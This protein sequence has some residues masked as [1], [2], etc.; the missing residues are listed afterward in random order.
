M[1]FEALRQG[2]THRKRR[3]NRRSKVGRQ[4]KWAF[5][6]RSNLVELL[7]TRC[8]LT[9]VVGPFPPNDPSFPDQWNLVNTGQVGSTP[10]QDINV[11]PA[12]QQGLT[13][14]G[15]TV[16]VVD[17]G[18]DPNHP[19]LAANYSSS[20]S[21][22]YLEGLQNPTPPLPLAAGAD[23]GT[24]MAGIIAAVANNG[25]GVSGVAPN[26]QFAALRAVGSAGGQLAPGT[27]QQISNAESAHQQQI[28]IYNNSWTDQYLPNGTN[29]PP[30]PSPTTQKTAY[31]M[32]LAAIQKG[33]IGLPKAN[34]PVPAGRA[35][36]GNIYVFAAGDGAAYND[37]VNYSAVANSP[38]VIAVGGVNQ[39]GMPTV[40]SDP[41]A[42]LLVSAPT[43]NDVLGAADE[44]GLPT[45]DIIDGP[46]VNG[47][48]TITDTYVGNDQ[49]GATGTGAA[50]AEVS[51][52]IALMLQ[53]NPKLSYRDV[54]MILAETAS[55]NDPTDPGWMTNTMSV[56]SDGAV[57]PTADVGSTPLPT[58]V[59]VSP[60]HFDNAFGF[61]VV[62]AAAAVALAKTWT[63]LQPLSTLSS[64]L[65]AVN[66]AI[67]DGV[68]TGV[69]SSVTFTQGLHVEHAQVTFQ[70]DILSAG[71]LQIT[72][73]S[74]NG[75]R[76]VL[77]AERTNDTTTGVAGGGNLN[78]Y[79][80]GWT[81]TTDEDWGENSAGTWTLQVADRNQ[82]GITGTFQNWTLNL[83]GTQDYAPI[84][85]NFSLSTQ[86][87]Q[88]ASFNVL[89][90]TYDTDGTYTIAPGS[91]SIL[92][93]PA[94]GTLSVNAQTGQI[95][96]TPNFGFSGADSFTYTV[97]DTNGV[98]SRTATV[99]LDVGKLNQTPVANN[100]STSTLAHT[101]VSIDIL[102]N[103]TDASGSLLPSTVKIVQQPNFGTVSV[104]PVTGIATYTP[105]PNFTV[106][107]S[108]QYTV[109]DS[110]GL[111]S[112]VATVTIN[113]T[114]STPVASSF[115]E[116]AADQNVVQ[117]INVLNFVTGPADPGHVTIITPPQNGTATVDPTTGI[118]RYTPLPNFFG[119]DSLN[120]AVANS[121]GALSNAATVSLTVLP[122]GLPVALNHEFVLVP[123]QSVIEG[124]RALDNP[125]NSGALVALLNTQP[126]FGTVTMN[127]DGSFT[128]AQGPSFPGID[129]FTYVVNNGQG[130][131]APATIRLVSPTVNYVEQLYRVVLNRSASDGELLYFAGQLNAGVSRAQVAAEFLGSSEYLGG[132]VNSAYEQVLS[133]PADAGGQIYWV[134]QMHAGLT[135][136]ALL[137][138]LAGS[139]EYIARH[140]GSNQAVVAGFY[141]TFL[142]R[143]A[144]FPD[145]VYWA[146]QISAGEPASL[147]AL[148]FV[149]SAEYRS[150]FAQSLFQ[151]DLHTPISAAAA[152]GFQSSLGVAASRLQIQI[153]ILSS[154]TFYTN[155]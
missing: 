17:T 39:Q 139:P 144:S 106:S 65:I 64:G 135:Q 19:D 114:Q 89:S 103:D 1:V 126:Q 3:Q 13:G 80:A 142:N 38:Y 116:P 69:S 58:G 5:L 51:G 125:T 68:A 14:Q 74:P 42:A 77:A 49:N 133:R 81:F 45:T 12:W 40:T 131:S 10:L 115:S 91:L 59:T 141:Q 105:G 41:G 97:H 29:N 66:Q 129:S 136:E 134:A 151:N 98:A 31:P 15:V 127:P 43:G 57:L 36:L 87:N 30:V 20:L 67:P 101:P 79:A 72:L 113:L 47:A 117:Q 109:S 102:A 8:L 37:N 73:I 75:T 54:Q 92:S 18:V 4:Q 33:A 108:F 25:V 107:D 132:F 100:D 137:A 2:T 71:D 99:T 152:Y 78:D 147:V 84:A 148:E 46:L 26:A 119:T 63:P 23:H 94:N 22:N 110:N 60:L 9:A 154:D 121:Q 95:V 85:Q 145:I 83:S 118:I 96:Y 155:G 120:Y 93:Q 48:P 52:V 44:N 56:T 82:N 7:E 140:G 16:G 138:I 143:T 123:G 128:Y 70:S 62:D 24:Q 53:A 90:H 146:N 153:A 11:L 130:N 122:Q 88:A 111:T 32:S 21:Y 6:Q 76:S 150:D 112:N 61:G 149:D 28:Q 104:N 27:D 124:V 35:G 86:Q 34:P 55:Q 50:A